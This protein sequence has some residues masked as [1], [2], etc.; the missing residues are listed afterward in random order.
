MV[1]GK[2]DAGNVPFR[3][4]PLATLLV[5]VLFGLLQC[6]CGAIDVLVSRRKSTLGIL[7]L[8]STARFASLLA[9]INQSSHRKRF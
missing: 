9:T 5:P 4:S 3:N 6:A 1:I 8:M 2:A 7:F